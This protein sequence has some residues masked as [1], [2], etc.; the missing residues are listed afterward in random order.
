M[1]NGSNEQVVVNLTQE[2]DYRL[3]IEFGNEVPALVADEPPPLGGGRAATARR[4]TGAVAGAASRGIG[5]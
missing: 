4:R 3:R 5:R 1:T 2:A